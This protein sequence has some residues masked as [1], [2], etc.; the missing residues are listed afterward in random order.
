MNAPDFQQMALAVEIRLDEIFADELSNDRQ[1]ARLMMKTEK[2]PLAKL[3]S[4]ILAIEWEVSER[5]LA[6]YLREVRILR[7]RYETDRQIQ[8]LLDILYFLG[9]YIKTYQSDTHPYVFKILTKVFRGLD[10]IVCGKY[11]HREKAIVVTEEVKRYLSLKAFLKNQSS[12]QGLRLVSKTQPARRPQFSAANGPETRAPAGLEDKN[13]E[14]FKLINKNL[15]NIKEMIFKELQKL[16][17]ELTAQKQATR[18]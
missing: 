5:H 6:E 4:S 8:K 9:R 11:S 1:N 2:E 18:R 7:K 12:R 13:A 3:Q 15:S 14:Y 16:R 17:E 10:K